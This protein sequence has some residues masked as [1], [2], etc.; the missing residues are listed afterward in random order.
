[1]RFGEDGYQLGLL[2]MKVL[3]DSDLK[4]PFEMASFW[5]SSLGKILDLV[6]AKLKGRFRATK[7]K[8]RCR[9]T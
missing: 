2:D 3:A 6:V 1:M 7:S 8:V 5:D 4:W 9:L